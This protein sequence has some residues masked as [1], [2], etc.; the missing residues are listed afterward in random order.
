MAHGYSEKMLA[1]LPT[2]RRDTDNATA[3]AFRSAHTCVVDS[4]DRA[5]GA[6]AVPLMAAVGCVG[7]LAME[8][9]AGS[10]QTGTVRALVTIFA[11]QLAKL[12][13]DARPVEASDRRLA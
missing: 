4:S 8:V 12:I 5:S 7:V 10:P 6:L 11:A 9:P 13:G 3:T 2:V 1:Q